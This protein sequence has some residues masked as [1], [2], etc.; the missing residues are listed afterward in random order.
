MRQM[1]KKLLLLT[2]AFC[3]S[4]SFVGCGESESTYKDQT[5]V[6]A[7]N[8]P[9]DPNA[10]SKPKIGIAWENDDPKSYELMKKVI[11]AAGATPV[12]L[13]QV[14]SG[15]VSYEGKNLSPSEID[16][17]GCIKEETAKLIKEV[18]Y[19]NSNV[20][21]VIGKLRG[22][23]FMG[24]DDIC[25]TLFEE[26]ISMKNTDK[27]DYTLERDISD[28]LLMSYCIDYDIPVLGLCRGMQML[29]LLSGGTITNVDTYYKML[30]KTYKDEHRLPKNAEGKVEDYTPHKIKILDTDSRIY[31]ILQ[32]EIIEGVPSWHHQILFTENAKNLMVSAIAPFDGVVEAVERSDK[33]Y[34]VGYQFHPEASLQ[35]RFK[36][37]DNAND[38]LDYESG[39]KF[40]T[41]FVAA[42][43]K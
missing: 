13:S 5:G 1:I 30:D 39:L 26:S 29:T 24:G 41:D 16:E 19:N 42:V 4:F 10:N 36:A 14:L 43:K 33:A 40:F 37:A 11:E 3:L 27:K 7:S 8:K 12:V 21:S 6:T 22:V 2:L 34:I 38:F 9:I 25:P 31:N 15:V 18:N 28:Y 23:V 20:S 32:Q 17:N 35:K